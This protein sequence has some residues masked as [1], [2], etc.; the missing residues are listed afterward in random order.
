MTRNNK[1]SLLDTV[2]KAHARLV[3]DR[4]MTVLANHLERLLPNEGT[5]LDVGC[6]NGVISK[7]IMSANPN[8]DIHGIDVLQRPRCEIPMQIYD[9]AEFPLAD[10][11]VDTV[12]FV[13]VLHHVPEPGRLLFEAKRVARKSIVIKDHLCNSWWAERV[14]ALMD[15]VGNRPH[16]VALP[17]NYFS[18]AQWQ[19]CWAELGI[20]PDICLKKLDLYPWFA[21][22]LIEYRLHFICRIPTY[23]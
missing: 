10:S 9:G 1:S 6:G 5:A 20:S 21:R 18:S 14:L 8:L 2:S 17:Y 4:R 22:P 15:W 19:E 16:G 23:I 13:D 12:F 3:L 11:S 7:L